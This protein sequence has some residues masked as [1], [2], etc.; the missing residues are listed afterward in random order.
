MSES[1]PNTHPIEA[2]SIVRLWLRGVGAHY[3]DEDIERMC[4]FL[5]CVP[6]VVS[7]DLWVIEWFLSRL[8]EL[9]KGIQL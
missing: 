1:V 8:R 6:A 9:S 3:T 2:D 4:R 5:G 7:L